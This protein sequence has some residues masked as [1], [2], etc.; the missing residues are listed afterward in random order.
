M[1][2]LNIAVRWTL[3]A[4]LLPLFG[5]AL[6]ELAGGAAGLVPVRR[7]LAL[8]SL[9]AAT[10]S[11]LGVA[12][13]TAAMMGAPLGDV[14]AADVGAMLIG[15]DAG[16]AAIVRMV[17]LLLVFAVALARPTAASMILAMVA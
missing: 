3:Y 2:T 4:T 10:L 17:L 7:L 5:V 6:F 8:G 12:V 13:T 1:E 14:T 15:T 16:K 9:A 11:A